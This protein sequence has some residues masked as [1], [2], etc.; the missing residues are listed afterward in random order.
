MLRGRNHKYQDLDLQQRLNAQKSAIKQRIERAS[1]WNEFHASLAD[2]GVDIRI[3]R[4]GA[5]F[6]SI[7]ERDGVDEG[8]SVAAS[9]IDRDFSRSALEKR[10]GAMT[11]ENIVTEDLQKT[12]DGIEI[13]DEALRQ[14]R[15]R[16]TKSFQSWAL[17][18]R[19]EIASSSRIGR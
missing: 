5:V 2:L 17:E 11:Q 18:H 13:S 6:V 10:F 12:D 15:H 19:E 14:E 4:N 8:T 1:S 16:G 9:R 3:R 7:G